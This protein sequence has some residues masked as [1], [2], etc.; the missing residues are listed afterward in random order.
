LNIEKRGVTRLLFCFLIFHLSL[1]VSSPCAASDPFPTFPCLEPNVRFWID[2]YTKHPTTKGLVHDATDLSVVY[3][4]IDLLPP[5]K[6]GARQ[7]NQKR[8]QVA[9]EQYKKILKDLAKNGD[10]QD[11]EKRRIADLFGPKASPDVFREAINNIRCQVG[12]MDRFEIGLVRSGAYLQRIK[13]I[14]RSHG[15]P[16]DLCYLPHVES[17]FNVAAFSKAGAAG[18]WQFTRAT[19]KKF[20]TVNKFLDERRDP[21]RASEAAA[22]LLKGNYERLGNWP[23]AITAYNHGIAG[24]LRAKEK[25][26]TYEVAFENYNGRLFKFASRNFYSEFLAARHVA[27]N[28][29]QYFSDIQL[30]KSVEACEVL[31]KGQ[32]SVAELSRHYEVD[33]ETLRALNPALGKPVMKGQRQVPKG[34]RLRLPADSAK[35][36]VV[37]SAAFPQIHPDLR[38]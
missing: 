37:S 23:M 30:N 17:S 13:A 36:L 1:L 34:Y 32:S 5:D 10:Q 12:Q 27:K 3:C 6:P 20:L 14:F 8:I 24:M 16:E 18:M 9:K 15:L 7:T 19:G 25:M 4:V 29:T 11:P 26:G 31:T 38:Q 35:G 21:I 33:P 22:K 28:Y 2:A